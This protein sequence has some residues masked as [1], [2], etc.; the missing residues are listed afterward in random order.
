MEK[1]AI[2]PIAS[3]IRSSTE[4]PGRMAQCLQEFLGHVGAAA[5]IDN[6]GDS[7]EDLEGDHQ[8]EEISH[9]WRGGSNGW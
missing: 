6:I 2:S 4:D 8:E 9:A 5:L 7:E 1:K 3:G